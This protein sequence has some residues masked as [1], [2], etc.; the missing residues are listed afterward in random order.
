M[1][2]KIIP[3]PKKIALLG[4]ATSAAALRA[5]HER[6][7][8]ALR[9]AGLIDRLKAVGFDVIDL[10]DTATQVFQQD[11]EHPRARNVTAVLKS[12]N[13]LRPRVEVASR[14][15]PRSAAQLSMAFAAG[16]C[17]RSRPAR[18]PQCSSRSHQIDDLG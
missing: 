11:D 3:Q 1:A 9:A 4:S 6:A 8:A 15:I 2:V 12:L 16:S 5:G 14:W 18:S 17:C 13:D 7:P 10:G